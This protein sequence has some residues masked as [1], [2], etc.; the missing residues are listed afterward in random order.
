MRDVASKA[1]SLRFL[2]KN[3]LFVLKNEMDLL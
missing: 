2:N 3:G 1:F